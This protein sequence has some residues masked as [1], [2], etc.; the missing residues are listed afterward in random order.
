MTRFSRREFFTSCA[1]AL[2][3]QEDY[4]KAEFCLN[5]AIELNPG[6]SYNFLLKGLLLQRKSPEEAVRMLERAVG[7]DPGC[8]LGL[9]ALG[10]LHLARGD[11]QKATEVFSKG[12]LQASL[13]SEIEEIMK[14]KKIV[15]AGTIRTV[16]NV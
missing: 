14:L 3:D 7:L 16:N 6:D 5:K 15:S 11:M 10:R 13:H 2:V 12:I 9:R 1:E 8:S 4:E